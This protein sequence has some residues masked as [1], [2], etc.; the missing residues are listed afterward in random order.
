MKKLP[1]YEGK[2]TLNSKKSSSNKN[3]DK[4]VY[5]PNN[6]YFDQ[7]STPTTII[8]ASVKTDDSNIV[9]YQYKIKTDKLQKSNYELTNQEKDLVKNVI[10]TNLKQNKITPG[11]QK[12]MDNERF[13]AL[14]AIE[15]GIYVNWTAKVVKLLNKEK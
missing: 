15:S 12:M 11:T 1:D 14:E 7:T 8:K 3:E 4:V 10:V 5:R 13:H 9:N 6:K 2:A